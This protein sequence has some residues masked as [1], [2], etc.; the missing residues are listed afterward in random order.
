VGR[1]AATSGVRWCGLAVVAV[2]SGAVA[3]PA[4]GGGGGE[5][6][7]LG[8]VA[9]WTAARDDGDVDRAIALIADDASI[10][11]FSLPDERADLV[12]LLEGQAAAGGE[13]EDSD[14]VETGELVMCRYLIRD[15]ILRRWDLSLTGTHTYRVRDG[16]IVQADRVHDD[17]ARRLVY[18][19]LD[20]FR[21]WV[22]ATHPETAAV[23]WPDRDTAAYSDPRGAEAMIS[24][25]DEYEPYRDGTP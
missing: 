24:L 25:L 13:M 14:C 22:E 10:L 12:D 7:P 1:L 11:G 20:R 18:L 4:C 5:S 2:V 3:F 19:E 21:S 17:D 23:I 9:A 16:K 6:G 15:E 8:V